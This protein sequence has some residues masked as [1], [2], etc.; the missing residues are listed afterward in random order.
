MYNLK[1][2]AY[3]TVDAFLDRLEA[4]TLQG[5]I[6]ERVQVQ[7]ALNG[8]ERSLGTA[9]STHAP[10]SLDE[11]RRLIHHMGQLREPQV[12]QVNL[13][14]APSTLETTMEATVNV[15]T[16]AVAKLTTAI[17]T[18]QQQNR[19]RQ[20]SQCTRCGGRCYSLSHCRANG[21]TML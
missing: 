15:L 8:M 3:E 12:P 9:I 14:T 4:Q 6:P 16:A 21:K 20:D 2:L 10:S 17:D 7:I 1:Q 18:S 5:H 19:S 11:V 13:A